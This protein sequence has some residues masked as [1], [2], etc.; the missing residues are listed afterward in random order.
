MLTIPAKSRT[1]ADGTLL[2]EV[3]TGMPDAEVEV[4]I[5]I[6]PVQHAGSEA[7]KDEWPEGYFERFASPPDVELERPPQGELQERLPIE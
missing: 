4:V 3:P 2:L 7:P 5:V 1:N 6:E